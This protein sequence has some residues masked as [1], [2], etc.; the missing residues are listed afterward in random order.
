MDKQGTR[1]ISPFLIPMFMPN[2]AAGLVAIQLGAQVDRPEQLG[3]P[4]GMVP[5]FLPAF[6][7]LSQKEELAI[8]TQSPWIQADT[9]TSPIPGT[10]VLICNMPT[11]QA[12]NGLFKQ[13]I[14]K[15][16]C[17]ITLLLL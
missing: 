5:V 3:L 6:I 11:L 12:R 17:V 8:S 9:R 10:Q 1:R 13:S 14:Q 15:E 4:K 2:G 16:L 7:L